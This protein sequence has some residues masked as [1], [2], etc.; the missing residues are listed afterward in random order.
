MRR[1][2][3]DVAADPRIDALRARMHCVEEPEFTRD[4]L[5]P[6]KRSIANGL[7]IELLDGTTL[8]EVIVEYPVG[9]RRRRS[10]GAPLLEA[11][12][13]RNLARR[14]DP[15]QQQR[16]LEASADVHRLGAMAVNDYVDLY[17]TAGETA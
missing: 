15:S 5:D 13:R 10:E 1:T 8:D 2:T 12:F 4:Y 7:T 3:D 11:K 6:A 14:F 9:H 17:V 16:I